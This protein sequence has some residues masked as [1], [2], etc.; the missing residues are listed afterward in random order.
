VAVE[1]L[2]LKEMRFKSRQMNR[3]GKLRSWVMC[4]K[5]KFKLDEQGIRLDLGSSQRRLGKPF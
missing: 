5:L 4:D 1:R 3:F 2:T